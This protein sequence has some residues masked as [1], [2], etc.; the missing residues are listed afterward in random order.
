MFFPPLSDQNS[1]YLWSSHKPLRPH[2]FCLLQ[3]LYVALITLLFGNNLDPAAPSLSPPPFFFPIFLFLA[4]LK[5]SKGSFI[6]NER[7]L[8]EIAFWTTTYSARGAL[9]RSSCRNVSVSFVYDV[10][11]KLREAS[12]PSGEEKE[13]RRSAN[14]ASN[15]HRSRFSCCVCKSNHL[16]PATERDQ[17]QF[18]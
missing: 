9:C 3:P 6:R 5:H 8:H 17:S 14:A 1:F 13:G 16:L 12:R 7:R 11:G 10:P 18:S 4:P 2:L 15:S